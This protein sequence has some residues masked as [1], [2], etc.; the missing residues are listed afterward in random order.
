MAGDDCSLQGLRLSWS[1]EIGRFL[2]SGLVLARAGYKREEVI[3]LS[4]VLPCSVSCCPCMLLLS[5]L[6]YA[7][8][9]DALCC[10]A[11][12]PVGPLPCYLSLLATRSKS[13][14]NLFFF[15]RCPSSG[16]CYSNTE[17]TRTFLLTC[18]IHTCCYT[19]NPTLGSSPQRAKAIYWAHLFNLQSPIP[20]HGR[21]P[22]FW[23]I[24][25]PLSL[26]DMPSWSI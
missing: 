1:L 3:P 7:P 19:I 4:R 13:Q 20:Q 25:F 5:D 26:L 9:Q 15:T 23:T 8:P 11:M 12:Q 24:C 14:V 18:L 21:M 6:S 17:Q 16:N 2:R 10:V 22:I